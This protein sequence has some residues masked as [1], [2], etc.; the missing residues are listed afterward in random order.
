MAVD[1]SSPLSSKKLM[2]EVNELQTQMRTQ[3]ATKKAELDKLV[4]EINKLQV[5]AIKERTPA[6]VKLLKDKT[7][8]LFESQIT[9][10]KSRQQNTREQLTRLTRL[11]QHP[12]TIGDAKLQ[13]QLEEMIKKKKQEFLQLNRDAVQIQKKAQQKSVDLGGENSS[14]TES[15]RSHASATERAKAEAEKLISEVKPQEIFAGTADKA[16]EASK[17]ID[18]INRLQAAADAGTLTEEE[19]K[20]LEERV[21]RIES[22][23]KQTRQEINQL[24]QAKIK[25]ELALAKSKEELNARRQ[26]EAQEEQLQAELNQLIQKKENEQRQLMEELEVIRSHTEQEAAALKAQ[27]DAA[28]ALAEKEALDTDLVASAHSRQTLI[29]IGSAA[30]AIVIF[31]GVLIFTPLLSVINQRIEEIRNPPLAEPK[32]IEKEEREIKRPVKHAKENEI[33]VL[34]K[35][36]DRLK[37]GGNGPVM[38]KLPGGSF[39]MG[40][41][42]YNNEKPPVKVTLGDFS[43]G[44][45]EVTFEEYDY[46]ARKTGRDLPPD[47][48]WERGSQPVINVSW[49]DASDYAKW[50]TAQTGHEYRLPSEREW[51]YAARAG[52]NSAYWWGKTLEKNRTNCQSCGSRWDGVSPAPVGSFKSNQFDLNDT[53]GNVMEWTNNCYHSNYEDAPRK[54]QAWEGGDC[55]K[56]VVR[57]GAY[58]SKPND[59][60]LSKRMQLKPN[61]TRKNL[62]FRVVRVD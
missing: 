59:L 14:T 25:Y 23:Q 27:R 57:G 6:Q 26:R 29:L 62:G 38:L 17:L 54:A 20:E 16:Q 7:R 60:R 31:V 11:Q 50:L 46:F 1:H 5:A 30:T 34:K 58:D 41:K 22:K 12:E 8:L 49:D 9:L 28:R 3:S 13:S 19:A 39:V 45:Y 32:T 56:R 48:E 36:R 24:T 2:A 40:N 42:N 21:M 53:V 44:K 10:T 4:A 33:R 52:S 35:Y 51:E 47:N 15:P 55:S 43:I 61:S 37:D 18:E